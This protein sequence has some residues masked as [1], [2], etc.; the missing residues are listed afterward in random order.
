M[1]A[2][3]LALV[4]SGLRG[5]S[6]AR[7]AVSSGLGR[8]VAVAEPDPYRRRSAAAEFGIPAERVY[9]DWTELAAQPRLADATI[10]ATQDRLHVDPAVRFADLGYHIL[11]EKPM[12]VAERDAV[13]ISEAAERNDILLAVCHVLRYTPYTRALRRLLESGAIGRLVS[14]QHLEPV[15]WWHQAHSFVRGNWRRQ[16][17]SAPMLLT[18][19]CH[20]IDWLIHLFGELPER[21]SSFGGLSHF[22]AEDRPEGAADRCLDCPLEPGC[23]YSAKRL[24]LGCLG[25]PDQEFWPLSAVTEDHTERGVLDALRTGPYGRCVYACDNDVV[26]HQVVNMEFA[27]GATCSFTMSAFTPM[28][29]RRTRLLGTHGFVDG[30][31]RTLRVVDFR[32]GGER[33]VDAVAATDI[34]AAADTSDTA[35]ADT[36]GGSGGAVGPSADDGHGGGDE[37]LTEAFLT[38]VATGDASALLS[39][40]AESLATHRVVWAAERA[41]V[42]GT[43]VRPVGDSSLLGDDVTGRGGSVQASLPL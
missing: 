19:S 12:A 23:P 22:R 2:V 4:G 14:V 26:D 9:T 31:G 17:T 29:H 33:T 27:S 21:V 37:A 8:V 3:T 40:A 13:A 10:I 32:T 35:A 30:D 28:E 38:A 41:R 15:G 5:R 39:D 11:L 7:H 1:A 6:Y 20:D 18:K 34:A 43:V 25:D 36:A 24:Y 16:D 42:T